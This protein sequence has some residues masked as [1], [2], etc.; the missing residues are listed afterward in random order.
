MEGRQTLQGRREREGRQAAKAGEGEKTPPFY[1]GSEDGKRAEG[2]PG[3]P[4]LGLGQAQ[5]APSPGSVGSGAA[6]GAVGLLG[7]EDGGGG[8]YICQ[9]DGNMSCS[10]SMD[11]EEE[12]EQGEEEDKEQ[13][14]VRPAPATIPVQLGHRPA[15]L[16]GD[17]RAPVL[18]TVLRSNKLVD[19]LSA[20]RISLYNV[21]SAWSKWDSIAEDIEMR[22]TDISILTEVWQKEENKRHQKCIESMLE[23]RGIKYVSTPRPGAQRGGGVALACSQE[24]FTLSKLNILVPKPLEACF[25]LV[26]PKNPTGKSNKYI[27]CSFYSPP[28]SRSNN[29]LSEFLAATLGTLRTEHPGARVILGGDVNDMR[30]GLLLSLDPTLRQV[31]Q[32]FTNKN[33]DKTLDVLLMD[34]A[35]IYQQPSILPPMTVDKGKVGKDSDHMGVEAL[36]RTNLASKGSQMRREVHVQPFPESGLAQFGL[37]LLSED[38]GGLEGAVDSADMV[39]R[40]ETRSALI[41]SRQFPTKTVLVSTQDLPYFTEEL[42]LLKRRRQRAY[43]KGKRSE[44]YLKCKAAFEKKEGL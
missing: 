22:S 7:G 30:L 39:D 24:R 31:V 8:S 43:K 44:N 13:E 21:R 1:R 36:P 15:P 17:L 3:P 11:S 34:C 6:R 2:G 28:R 12:G 16:P 35:D 10:T 9:L 23:L 5:T 32:G 41:V 33:H 38:W 26:K 29:K 27:F 42:R 20:P 14:E 25:A 4:S 40:F 19:A 37:T 18:R